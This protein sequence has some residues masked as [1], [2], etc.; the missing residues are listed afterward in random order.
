LEVL[1]QMTTR[2][3]SFEARYGAGANAPVRILP[4]NSVEDCYDRLQDD[5]TKPSL[6]TAVPFSPRAD[7]LHGSESSKRYI[8]PAA[9]E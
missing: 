6:F 3:N 2:H 9:V 7:L 8:R 4:E 5:V 1:S